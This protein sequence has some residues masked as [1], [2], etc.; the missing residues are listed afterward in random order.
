VPSLPATPTLPRTCD[1]YWKPSLCFTYISFLHRSGDTRG[2]GT[3][4]YPL[5]MTGPGLLCTSAPGLDWTLGQELLHG[6]RA[7]DLAHSHH[8]A[9][10]KGHGFASLASRAYFLPSALLAFVRKQGIGLK[11]QGHLPSAKAPG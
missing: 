7:Q 10:L 11:V 8:L 1:Q 6:P 3:S 4:V 9:S 2:R 5:P